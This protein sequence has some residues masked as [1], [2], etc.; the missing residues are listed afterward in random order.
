MLVIYY[1]N[2]VRDYIPVE[3]YLVSIIISVPFENDCTKPL[4]SGIVDL[5]NI[6]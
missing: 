2:F 3:N 4:F 1:S 6:D 5:A